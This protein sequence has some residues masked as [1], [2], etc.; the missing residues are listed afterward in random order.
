MRTFVREYPPQY[1]GYQF[2]YGIF[3]VMEAGEPLDELYTAGFLPAS[4]DLAE[5]R[6][7]FYLARSLRVRLSQLSLDKK[8]R[9]LQRR[10]ESAGLHWHLQTRQEFQ[11]QASHDW[12]ERALQWVRARYDPPYL[13]PARLDYLLERPFLSHVATIRRDEQPVAYVLLPIGERVAHF[14]FSLYDPS[15]APELS[16]GKWILGEALRA[17]A[18]YGLDFLYLGTCYGSRS[19]YKFQGMR[20]GVSFFDGNAWSADVAELERRLRHDPES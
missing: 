7:L 1:A 20:D 18:E 15:C 17:L 5:A 14:W 8:R 2:N 19:A 6:P 3:A 9:Y 13:T 4:Q 10:G 16:L 11:A 12:K